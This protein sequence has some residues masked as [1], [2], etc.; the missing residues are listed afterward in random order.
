MGCWWLWLVVVLPDL[1]GSL[2]G[3]APCGGR[4]RLVVHCCV[5]GGRLSP[6]VMV[7]MAA[8]PHPLFFAVTL[9]AGC[10]A[11]VPCRPSLLCPRPHGGWFALSPV[12]GRCWPAGDVLLSGLV[13]APCPL[14]SVFAGCSLPRGW[15]G[16]APSSPAVGSAGAIL[17]PAWPGSCLPWWGVYSPSW[18]CGCC[19]CCPLSPL[20]DGLSHLGGECRPD[21]LF[22]QYSSC[23]WVGSSSPRF[24]FLGSGVCLFL[25]LPSFRRCMHWAVDAVTNWTANRAVACRHVVCGHGLCPSLVSLWV[26]GHVLAGRSSHLVGVRLWRFRPGGCA[27]RMSG[28]CEVRGLGGGWRVSLG[29]GLPGVCLVPVPG[30]GVWWVLLSFDPWWF[31]PAGRCKRGGRGLF[32]VL[33]ALLLV[34]LLGGGEGGVAALSVVRWMLPLGFCCLVRWVRLTCG[35]MLFCGVL[36]HW[37][38]FPHYRGE[39]RSDRVRPSVSFF[40]VSPFCTPRSCVLWWPCGSGWGLGCGGLVRGSVVPRVILLSGGGWV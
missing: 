13:V 28:V 14:W 16:W 7:P 22:W 26:Y 9:A 27:S 40:R 34:P 25:P 8:P 20:V 39:M 32:L 18:V 31:F 21:G 37:L 35:R 6:L 17:V 15:A 36:W 24:F 12:G 3:G 29:V 2:V 38:F 19:P 11:L 4:L 23:S 5:S 30:V 33:L 10:V 1:L